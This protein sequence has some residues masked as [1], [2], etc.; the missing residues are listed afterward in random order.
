MG[1][2]SGQSGFTPCVLPDTLLSHC[3]KHK[4]FHLLIRRGNTAAFATVFSQRSQSHR[5]VLEAPVDHRVLTFR[6]KGFLLR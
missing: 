5:K 3:S 4:G 1:I 6:G 2:K